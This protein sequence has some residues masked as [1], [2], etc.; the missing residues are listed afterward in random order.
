[1]N[2]I[3]TAI[4]GGVF[5][6]FSNALLHLS[7]RKKT[8]AESDSI[9]VKTALDLIKELNDFKADL[10]QRL[11]DAERKIKEL[12]EENKQLYEEIKSLKNETR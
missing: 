7:G 4:I 10:E 11:K 5:G 3:W 9:I 6:F 1:M 12:Q 2:S 8:N